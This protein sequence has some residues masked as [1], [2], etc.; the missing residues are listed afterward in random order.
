M[1]A[2]AAPLAY[3]ILGIV[4]LILVIAAAV[5]SAVAVGKSRLAQT[6]IELLSAGNEALSHTNEEQ[7]RQIETLKRDL[8]AQKA[9]AEQR[10]R[11]VGDL[12]TMV[13]GV[14]A[15]KELEARLERWFEANEEAQSRLAAAVLGRDR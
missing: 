13:Q 15:I 14:Q 8:D 6:T 7:G 11:Q 2:S 1:T 10:D 9:L 4:S 3:D 12:R 5:G